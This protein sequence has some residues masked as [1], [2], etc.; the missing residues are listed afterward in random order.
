[1]GKEK[2]QKNTQSAKGFGKTGGGAMAR[3]ESQAQNASHSRING[4]EL[5]VIEKCHVVFA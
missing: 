1:M 4:T 2:R 3:P 5:V